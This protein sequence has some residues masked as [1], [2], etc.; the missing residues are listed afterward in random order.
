[1][2]RTPKTNEGL[3]KLIVIIVIALLLLAFL[4]LNLRSIVNSPTFQ[5]NW[6]FIKGIVL[7]IWTRFLKLP[8]L[9]I[10]NQGFVRF[11]WN[12]IFQNLL[13]MNFGS[14]G[15]TPDTSTGLFASTSSI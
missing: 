4:G 7:Q 5:D 8:V 3:I 1:M 11:I 14:A 15:G 2:T 12:P 10:W 13:H 9:F 6:Q